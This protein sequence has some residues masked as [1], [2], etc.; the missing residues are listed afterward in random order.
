AWREGQDKGIEEGSVIVKVQKTHSDAGTKQGSKGKGK[1]TGKG[2]AKAI[3]EDSEDPNNESASE[4]SDITEAVPPPPVPDVQAGSSSSKKK[5]RAPPKAKYAKKVDI[6]TLDSQPSTTSDP[7]TPSTSE[8]PPPRPQPR[9]ILSERERS[10]PPAPNAPTME[11]NAGTTAQGNSMSSDVGGSLSHESGPSDFDIA[12]VNSQL[13]GVQDL[14]P[15]DSAPAVATPSTSAPA[16]G[17]GEKRKEPMPGAHAAGS[18]DTVPTRP[19]RARIPTVKQHLGADS[20]PAS[21]DRGQASEG[22]DS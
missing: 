15:A 16:S 19:R 2:K 12:T 11:E 9:R 3:E 7:A 4:K 13:R 21:C 20:H 5:K 22:G 14:V 17:R 8:I 1:A 10:S 18:G 6:M